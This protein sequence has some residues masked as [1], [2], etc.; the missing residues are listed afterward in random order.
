MTQ[1]AAMV[2]RKIYVKMRG[3]PQSKRTRAEPFDCRSA[4]R[5]VSERSRYGVGR[6]RREVY[7]GDSN[8][9]GQ[10]LKAESVLRNAY[11]A[12]IQIRPAPSM[13]RTKAHFERAHHLRRSTHR[14]VRGVHLSV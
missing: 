13:V 3:E 2:M 1:W 7:G 10:K 12:R 8:R 11:C 5:L 9:Q 4:H 6:A 14:Q